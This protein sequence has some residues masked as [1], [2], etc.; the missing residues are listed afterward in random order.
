MTQT[1][2]ILARLRRNGERGLTPIEALADLGCFRLGARVW[3][4]RREG[5]LIVNAWQETN[6]KR[7][8]RYVLVDFEE[9]AVVVPGQI[10]LAL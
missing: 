9:P 5:H 3:D 2:E 1:E 6:G 4:L 10:E 8:A 7:Y